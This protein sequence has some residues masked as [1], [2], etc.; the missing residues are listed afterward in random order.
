MAI[1]SAVLQHLVH[2]TKCKTLFITHYPQVATDLVRRYPQD[3]ENLHMGYTE[4]TRIDGTREVTFLYRL[5]SGITTES[6][7]VECA[8]LANVPEAILQTASERSHNM[9][10]LIEK[11]VRRNKY[12]HRLPS[13]CITLIISDVDCTNALV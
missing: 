1:A 13:C 10:A 8:R 4:E 11:R 5:T 9:R 6:F 3:L 12:V 7:G 2:T